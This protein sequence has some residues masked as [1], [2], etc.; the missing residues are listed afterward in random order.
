M[1]KMITGLLAV[2]MLLGTLSGCGKAASSG[3]DSVASAPAQETTPPA[4]T[5]AA[6]Q[7][8]PSAAE[9]SAQ[10]EVQV[11]AQNFDIPMPLT[12]EPVTFTYFMRFN[13]QVQDWCQDMSD[14]LFYSTLEEMS[15]VHIEF[16]LFHP[17]NFGEQFNL[18]MASQDYADFYCEAASGYTGGYDK[19]VEDEVF[20]DLTPY[21]EEYAPNYNA[22]INMNDQ[23]RRDAVTDEGRVVF[24]AAAY[25]DGQPCAKGPMIRAD[26]AREFGMDPAERSSRA[27]T[28][29]R[30]RDS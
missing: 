30:A 25:D 24:F 11:A 9:T 27:A 5:Q 15:G 7:D 14:N 1:K 18:Q 16:Q 10:E 26:W 19:G 22:I 23:N 28:R 21:I 12:E 17:M 20:L 8:Q 2:A 3:S 13:P 4:Q 29:R 6:E